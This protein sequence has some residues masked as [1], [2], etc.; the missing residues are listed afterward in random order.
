M[1]KRQRSNS[2]A[3]RTRRVWLALLAAGCL[4]LTLSG[5]TT[6]VDQ[7]DHRPQTAS[8]FIGRPRPSS[9]MP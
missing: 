8:E 3:S 5:C 9:V 6:P 2:A 4:S 7:I 1:P